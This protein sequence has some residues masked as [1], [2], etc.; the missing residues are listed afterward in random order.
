MS[1]IDNRQKHF[2]RQI[3]AI[4]SRKMDRPALGRVIDHVDHE[5]HEA[6][7]EILPR[8]RFAAQAAIQETAIDFR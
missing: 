8:S 5:A 4:R 7:N 2:G 3:L 1:L 6:I